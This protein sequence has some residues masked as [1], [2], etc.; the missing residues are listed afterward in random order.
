MTKIVSVIAPTFRRPLELQEMLESVL[1]QNE[2]DLEVIVVDD[3][4]ERSAECVVS[5]L[6][7]P[8]IQYK[9]NPQPSGGRPSMVRNLGIPLA[10][11]RYIHFLDDDDK[12]PLGHYAAMVE[13]FEAHPSVGV[14]Y[15]RVQPFGEDSEKLGEEFAFFDGAARRAITAQRLGGK[16]VTSAR[17]SFGRTLLV[18]GAAMIR[19]ECVDALGGFNPDLR[20]AEDVDFYARGIRAFGGLFTERV[21]L[22]YRIWENSIMHGTAL[23][24]AEVR[25]CYRRIH[26]G[27]RS[28][29]GT[30]DYIT[31][32]FLCRTLFRVI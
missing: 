7:D 6:N 12:A 1:C 14:I 18:C 29:H 2:V 5:S 4:P 24:H 9:V 30:L 11:G 19:R 32:S 21:T 26:A 17:L 16:W 22:Q 13:A 3:S 23:D 28:R 10:K 31:A 8:R 15:G 25:D 27:Y 20:I